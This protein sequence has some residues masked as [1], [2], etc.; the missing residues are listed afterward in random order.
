MKISKMR[1]L[2]TARFIGRVLLFLCAVC[3]YFSHPEY[4]EIIKNFN[5]FTS[6]NLLTVFYVIWTVD[7]VLQ[8]M[9]LTEHLLMGHLKQFKSYLKTINIKQEIS[10]VTKMMKK[11]VQSNV[12]ALKVLIFWVILTV[13]IGMLKIFNIITVKELFLISCLFYVCDLICVLFYC[14][15]RH[16]L[17]KNKCCA[18][19]R[20]FNWDH[21]MMFSPFIFVKGFY[22]WSLVA[23]SLVGMFMWEFN[24]FAHPERF[25]E[26]S[27]A[28]LKCKNCKDKMCGKI[29]A[30]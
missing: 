4:I 11:Q 16:L 6:F 19:C 12:G 7:I 22:S 1:K 28:T 27:N 3:T 24:Y 18:T 23:L 8:F 26:E 21:I 14:P 10:S 17:M 5:I 15:F 29:S 20:I 30:R 25:F 9:P 2:Y 13:I